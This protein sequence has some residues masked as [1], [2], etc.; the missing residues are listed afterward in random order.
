MFRKKRTASTP[1]AFNLGNSL[2][3]LGLQITSDYRLRKQRSPDELY[4]FSVSK[5]KAYNE[6]YYQAVLEHIHD[7]TIA[8]CMLQA[9]PISAKENKT[10][11]PYA[12]V[13]TTNNWREN[14][15]G[16]VIIVQSLSHPLIWTNRN[17]KEHDLRD[18][19]VVNMICG[20]VNMGYAVAIFTPSA[21]LWDTHKKI[22]RT[23]SS[24]I[25]LG[26]QITKQNYIPSI[27][28][29]EEYVTK[30][31]NYILSQSKALK[32][33]YIGAE[34]GSQPLNMY[35]DR[36]WETL[37]SRAA[38]VIL[39]MNITSIYELNNQNYLNYLSENCWNYNP[40]NR[41]KQE[42]LVDLTAATGLK[43]FSCGEFI[44]FIYDDITNI[45]LDKMKNE[46]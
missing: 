44:E 45:L 16:L 41:P 13:Y 12:F 38:S 24:F 2:E 29:P 25:S 17:V 19:T 4:E 43:T 21:L 11:E 14:T 9:I 3:D 30:G 34:Y 31:L 39:L 37:S 35:L 23:I 28:S 5:D 10:D 32:I 33:Y 42:L 20:C 36:N 26:D 6:H 27:R 8:T 7:W 1:K 18:A 22:P 15:K 40:S 46:S